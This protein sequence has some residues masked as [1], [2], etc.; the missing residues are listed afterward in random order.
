VVSDPNG[1]DHVQWVSF[2]YLT[3][4]S[5]YCTVYRDIIAEESA[6]KSAWKISPSYWRQTV[7]SDTTVICYLLI[8]ARFVIM[9]C[10]M[11]MFER[12]VTSLIDVLVFTKLLQKCFRVRN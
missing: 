2:N 12:F 8:R 10:L 1:M 4:V 7:T 5:I 9:C 11:C 6:V 3:Q